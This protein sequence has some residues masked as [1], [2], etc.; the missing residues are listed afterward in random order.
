MEELDNR[1]QREILEAVFTSIERDAK[2][3]THQ[4]NFTFVFSFI[5]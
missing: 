2:S 1:K 3:I 4:D 5:M